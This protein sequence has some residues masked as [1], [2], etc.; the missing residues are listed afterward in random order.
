MSESLQ[1]IALF[2]FFAWAQPKIPE[3]AFA[4]HVPNG[5]HRNARVGMKLKQEGVKRG[6]PDIIIPV[7]QTDMHTGLTY[8]GIVIEMKYKR[9]KL[10]TEQEAWLNHFERNGWCTI[11]AYDWTYAAYH[12]VEYFGKN[13][14][15]FG[16]HVS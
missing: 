11:V 16:L 15:D 12:V 8:C 1:Q 5:G 2:E 14:N 7:L 6:V 4:F 9:N 3:L 10:S 13:P